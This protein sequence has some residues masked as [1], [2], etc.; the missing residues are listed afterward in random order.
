MASIAESSIFGSF[1][2]FEINNLAT[3]VGD[4]ER[5]KVYAK[6]RA[7]SADYSLLH[8]TKIDSSNLLTD[9]ISGSIENLG[10]FTASYSNGRSY[11]YYWTTQSSANVSLDSVAIYKGIKFQNNKV[12]TNLGDN[13][14]LER[15]SEYTVEFY[16]YYSGSVINPE[17]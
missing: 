1:A 12:S 6:S 5:V 15:G 3:F 14:R 2:R 10:Y 8:D 13:I 17:I 11:N 16:T 9:V 4:V 7:S